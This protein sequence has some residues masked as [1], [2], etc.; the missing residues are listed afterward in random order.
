[1]KNISVKVDI[2]YDQVDWLNLFEEEL[3]QVQKD[4]NFYNNILEE[5]T[6]RDIVLLELNSKSD[7][8]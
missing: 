3:I 8:T 5:F 6:A 7:I 1:M 2:L 4:L